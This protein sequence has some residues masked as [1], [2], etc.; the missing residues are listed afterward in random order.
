M[1]H[2]LCSNKAENTGGQ[3]DASVLLAKFDR[4]QLCI[5]HLQRLGKGLHLGDRSAERNFRVDISKSVN[6]HLQEKWGLGI[7]P[8]FFQ[9][10]LYIR[11][12]FYRVGSNPVCS[13]YLR[14]VRCR[15]APEM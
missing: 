15:V 4:S 8:H 14:K 6:Y 7:M 11:F 13:G 9:G 5:F 12:I 1:V 3:P 2:R 10:M